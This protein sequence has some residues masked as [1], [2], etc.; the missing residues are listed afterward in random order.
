MQIHR[1][2]VTSF[3]CCTPDKSPAAQLQIVIWVFGF[4]RILY[5]RTTFGDTI[6]SVELPERVNKINVPPFFFFFLLSSGVRA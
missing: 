1:T 6:L 3:V 4:S 5:R 2:S